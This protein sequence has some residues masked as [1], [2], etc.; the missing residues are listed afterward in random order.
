MNDFRKEAI[1]ASQSPLQFE[2]TIRSLMEKESIHLDD[3][4]K[5]EGFVENP[6]IR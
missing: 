1:Q 5:N 4:W 3:L 2:A 6:S